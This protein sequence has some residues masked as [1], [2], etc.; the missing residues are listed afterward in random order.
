MFCTTALALAMSSREAVNLIGPQYFDQISGA[1]RQIV[2]VRLCYLQLFCAVV[3]W[4]HLVAEWMYLGR[5]PRRLWSGLLLLLLVGSLAGSVWLGPKLARLQRAQFAANLSP[6]QRE[7]V[8]RSFQFWDGVYQVV[9][10]IMISGVTVYFWRATR[11]QDEP[12]FV[13]PSKFR[14]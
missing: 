9:N 7:A 10:V 12:R 6:L 8:Q 14:S 1:L 13:G 3:A 11:T 5:I 4:L 2:I